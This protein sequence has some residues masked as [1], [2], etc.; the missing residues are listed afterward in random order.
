MLISILLPTV[1]TATTM[2]MC[3][4]AIFLN[5]SRYVVEALVKLATKRITVIAEAIISSFEAVSTIK[6][7][8]G[9]TPF[10]LLSCLP[11]I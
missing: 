6:V 2:I 1:V 4:Y 10:R 8:I 11:V 7:Y 9:R 3:C 5:V